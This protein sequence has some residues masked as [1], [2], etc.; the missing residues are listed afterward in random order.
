VR[1]FIVS[2]VSAR[3]QTVAVSVDSAASSLSISD[4][5]FDRVFPDEVRCL[6][7]QH[8][9]PIAV[10]ARAA[11][12]LRAS[13]ATRVLDIGSGPG[14]FCIVGALVTELAFYGVEQRPWLVN[15][16]RESA[17]R[18]GAHR[19]HFEH[20]NVTDVS[21]EPY[22]AFYLFNPFYEQI[23]HFVRQVDR[24][25]NRS[26]ATYDRYVLAVKRKLAATRLGTTVVT[27]NGFGGVVP[28]SFA[29]VGQESAGSD[30]L[31]IWAR[32]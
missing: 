8:W 5:D 4:D 20:A 25:I 26:R 32:R 22:D 24:S 18:L 28:P 15:V 3:P 7:S 12:I 17:H 11:E 29:Q 1:R 2:H 21:F 10:A 9:T 31:E 13:G 23:S 19:A 6:S 27:Y 30:Q 14:K 16:A